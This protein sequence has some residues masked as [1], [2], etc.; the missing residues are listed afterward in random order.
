MEEAVLLSIDGFMGVDLPVSFIKREDAQW[1]L[2]HAHSS[3]NIFVIIVLLCLVI[4]N[5]SKNKE[6]KEHS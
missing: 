6:A 1:L 4:E 2:V 3:Y 5:L